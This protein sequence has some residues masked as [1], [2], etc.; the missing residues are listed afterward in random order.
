MDDIDDMEDYEETAAHCDQCCGTGT[1][2]EDNEEVVCPKCKGE[3]WLE[4]L[5]Y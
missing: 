3:G 2:R 4:Y 5:S 1:L